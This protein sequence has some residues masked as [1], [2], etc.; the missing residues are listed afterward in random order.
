MIVL[1]AFGLVTCAASAEVVVYDNRGPTPGNP[2][3]DPPFYWEP[4]D[5]GSGPSA[6]LDVTVRPSAQVTP[7]PE[8]PHT[9][10]WWGISGGGSDTYNYGEFDRSD[11]WTPGSEFTRAAWTGTLINGVDR[12]GDPYQH[13]PL[14]VFALGNT[15][16]PTADFTMNRARFS[17]SDG[18]VY[19]N[20]VANWGIVGLELHLPSGTHYGFIAFNDFGTLPSPEFWGW[21]T[22]PDTPL[23]LPDE[24]VGTIFNECAADL[25]T[26]GAG[27]G[28]PGYGVPDGQVTASDINFFVNAWAAGDIAV[29]DVTTQGAGAGD[30]GFGVPDGL[31]TGSDINYYVNLWVAGCP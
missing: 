29:A 24:L 19:V 11:A 16:G 20:H 17:Y 22:T 3:A 12:N 7:D 1:G 2:G 27:V 25:T 6:H 13:P 5:W 4:Q 14:E 18:Y 31:V 9:L 26:Q 23:V 21:E 28:D 10:T 15:I 30:P 8:A